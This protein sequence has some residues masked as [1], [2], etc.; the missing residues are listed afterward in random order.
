MAKVRKTVR[1]LGIIFIVIGLGIISYPLYTNLVMKNQEVEILSTWERLS[2]EVSVRS[3]KDLEMESSEPSQAGKPPFKIM[4]PKINAEWVVNAGTDTETLQKGPGHYTGTA[5]PGETGRSVIAGHR[6]TYGAPFH[7]I[8]LLE[9]GDQIILETIDKEEFVYLV[10]G[11]A[12]VPPSDIS[13]LQQTEYATLAL[14]TCT[15]KFYA[16]R[17]LIVYAE[18]TNQEK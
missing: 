3:G 14:T 13:V 12:E 15:P 10:T 7:K 17:R 8:D 18:L 16:T 4:I 1:V 5:L 9:N 2:D 6:T 11:Q